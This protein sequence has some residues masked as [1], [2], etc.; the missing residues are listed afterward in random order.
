MDCPGSGP[1]RYVRGVAIAANGPVEIYYET[2]GDRAD[3]TLLLVNGLGSQMINWEPDFCR[4][5]VA[6]GFHVVA[7]DNR[8]VGLSSK[9]GGPPPDATAMA[10][11]FRTGQRMESAPYTL[12]DMAGDGFAVLDALE[13]DAAHV[14]GMSMGGMIVQRMAIDRP[15]RVRSMTSIMSTTGDRSV[16]RATPEAARV[17]TEPAPSERDAYVDQ[18][19]GHRRITAGAYFDEDYWR[20]LVGRGFDR[21]FH[22]MGT[23]FQIAAVAADGDRTEALGGLTVPTLVIHGGMDPLITPSGG[24][25]TAAAVAGAEL[26]V[27]DDMGHDLPEQIWDRVV[28]AL[29]RVAGLPAA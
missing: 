21:M 24:E 15:D 5:L 17:L 11:A 3:P 26:L 25:A 12:S 9:T 1:L 29:A 20:E 28:P 6:A 16:G 2:W 19:V 18:A 4:L 14:A 23:A 13:V 22:P 10:V 27:L 7:F 8:D